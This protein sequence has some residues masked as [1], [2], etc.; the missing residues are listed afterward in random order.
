MEVEL[1]R[2][3]DDDNDVYNSLWSMFR[4]PRN[5]RNITTFMI[6]YGRFTVDRVQYE[7]DNDVYNSLWPIYRRPSVKLR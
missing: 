5:V 2:S 1:W 7:K 6:V 4:Q 3:Y